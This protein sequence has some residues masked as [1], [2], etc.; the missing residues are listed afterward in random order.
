MFEATDMYFNRVLKLVKILCRVRILP[1]H[2][3]PM[4]ERLSKGGSIHQILIF[5]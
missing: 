3:K 5:I 1:K 4:F 2:F